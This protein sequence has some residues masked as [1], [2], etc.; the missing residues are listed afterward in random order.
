MLIPFDITYIGIIVVVLGTVAIFFLRALFRPRFPI[1]PKKQILSPSEIEFLR[2]LKL[3]VGNIYDIFPQVAIAKLIQVPYK[4]IG[5]NKTSQK[6]VDFVLVDKT[7]FATKLIIE[8]D[9][10]SHKLVERIERD[11]FVDKVLANAKIPILHQP[12]QRQYNVQ[13]L[14]NSIQQAISQNK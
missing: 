12:W 10:A 11:K 2:I 7:N 14:L 6:S 13:Q 8:L 9:D 5:W 3:A 1:Y 4:S